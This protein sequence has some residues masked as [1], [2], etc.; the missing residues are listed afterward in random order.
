MPLR[1]LNPRIVVVHIVQSADAGICKLS[2]LYQVSAFTQMSSSVMSYTGS[3]KIK[4]FTG[5]YR[6][7]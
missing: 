6:K 3:G 5:I 7:I 1:P 4:K 2:L